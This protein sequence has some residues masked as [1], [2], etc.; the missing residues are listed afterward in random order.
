VV[1]RAHCIKLQKTLF[2]LEKDQSKNQCCF[3]VR[4]TAWSTSNASTLVFSRNCFNTTRFC[5]V[6]LWCLQQNNILP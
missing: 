5:V 1:R 3:D 2:W 4:A 6:C